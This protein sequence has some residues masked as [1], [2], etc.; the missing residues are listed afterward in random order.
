MYSEG[1][2]PSRFENRE[3]GCYL[4]RSCKMQKQITGPCICFNSIHESCLIDY[5]R[6]HSDQ[7]QSVG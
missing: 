3:I 6:E 4:C 1:W 7:I 5:I 2:Y